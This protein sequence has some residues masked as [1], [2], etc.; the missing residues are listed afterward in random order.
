M[1]AKRIKSI[2]HGGGKKENRVYHRSHRSKKGRDKAKRDGTL[3]IYK[4]KLKKLE[5]EKKSEE[6][7]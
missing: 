7:L 5:D 3:Y 2:F 4:K 6:F 1:P